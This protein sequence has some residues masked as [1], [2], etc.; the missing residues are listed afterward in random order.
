MSPLSVL[1]RNEQRIVGHDGR[2]RFLP[3][4]PGLGSVYTLLSSTRVRPLSADSLK[5]R[6]K[7][8]RI[9]HLF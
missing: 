8:R 2:G 9:L 7:N 5:T 4:T 1:P 6:V 3:I